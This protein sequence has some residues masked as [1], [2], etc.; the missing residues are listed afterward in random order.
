MKKKFI[1][2]L[3]IMFLSMPVTSYAGSCPS[4]VLQI[5]SKISNLDMTKYGDIIAV[6]IT[7]KDKGASEHASGNHSKSEDLLNGALR[8]LD[9]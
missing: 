8:L 2:L 5:E 9:V 1:T 7:L 4:I 6:A 3:F